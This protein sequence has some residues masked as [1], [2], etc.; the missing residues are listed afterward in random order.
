MKSHQ[1]PI[2]VAVYKPVIGGDRLVPVD[3]IGYLTYMI[4]LE[5]SLEVSLDHNLNG[6]VGVHT[7]QEYM[8]DVGPGA[9]LEHVRILHGNNGAHLAVPIGHDQV[10]HKFAGP[11]VEDII[12]NIEKLIL[13]VGADLYLFLLFDQHLALFAISPNCLDQLGVPAVRCGLRIG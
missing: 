8:I 10:I 13:I 4:F 9:L 2:L 1:V 5:V 3:G 12:E 6:L 11:H 7:K